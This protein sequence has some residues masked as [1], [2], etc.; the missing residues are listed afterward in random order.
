M[1]VIFLD[2]DGVLNSRAY[3]RVRNWND[4][5]TFIDK[6]RLT[7]LKEIVDKTGA[8]IVLSTTWR[9]HWN[10]RYELRDITGK[11]IVD[12]FTEAGLEIYD[13]TPNLGINAE[14]YDEVK[15]WLEDY[16]DEVE[17]FVILDDYMYGWKE[18]SDNFIRTEPHR[19]LGL[20]EEHV[21]KAIEILNKKQ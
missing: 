18:L 11:I 14:R 16:Q 8:V 4:E 1:K 12:I 7:L 13:K 5:K 9:N 10:K 17:S 21:Q 6:T 15:A 19:T 3:D 20:L 2:F